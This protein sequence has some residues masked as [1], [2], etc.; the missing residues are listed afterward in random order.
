MV[1]HPE[2]CIDC[3]A[4]VPEC[5]VSAILPTEEVPEEE[6]KYIDVAAK[7]FEEKDPEEV[8]AARMTA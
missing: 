8:E 2:E 4:C 1:I 7:F 3:D 6:Q 5:P